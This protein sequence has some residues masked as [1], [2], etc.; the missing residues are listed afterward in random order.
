MSLLL[1]PKRK[2]MSI[3]EPGSL[4]SI[5]TVGLARISHAA[6]EVRK[7]WIGAQLLPARIEAQPNQPMRPLIE[8][9]IEPS[10]GRVLLTEARMDEGNAIR[11]YKFLA[12]QSSQL[13]QCVLSFIG[14]AG[15]SGDKSPCGDRDRPLGELLFN[16]LKFGKRIVR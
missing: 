16:A 9:L 7:T 10:E 4:P 2:S 5:D 13:G 14:A 1:D 12:C 3:P 11:R 15:Y 6:Y 8:R